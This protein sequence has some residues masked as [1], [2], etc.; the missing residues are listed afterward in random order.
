MVSDKIQKTLVSV[1]MTKNEIA[2]YL[3]LLKLGSSKVG[4]ISKEAGTNRS[5]SYDALKK[6]LEKGLVSYVI[7]GKRK[8]FRPVSPKRLKSLLQERQDTEK[9]K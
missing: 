8:Y 1:G 5:Y 2:V 6:L 7:M 3:A 9:K 4:A